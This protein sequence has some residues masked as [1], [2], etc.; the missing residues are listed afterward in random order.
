MMS[1]GTHTRMHKQSQKRCESTEILFRS[2]LLSNLTRPRPA[3]RFDVGLLL[4]DSDPYAEP[5][6]WAADSHISLFFSLRPQ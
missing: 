4:N 6:S 3:F 2:E 1:S 5:W